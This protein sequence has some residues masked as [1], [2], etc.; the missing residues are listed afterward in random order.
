MVSPSSMSNC[1]GR[2][3][4]LDRTGGLADGTMNTPSS[5]SVGYTCK[6]FTCNV[7]PAVGI[8]A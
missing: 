7:R 6:L 8:A 5:Q 3:Q 1:N 4:Q 2:Q